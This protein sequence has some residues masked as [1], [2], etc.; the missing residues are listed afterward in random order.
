MRIKLVTLLVFFFIVCIHRILTT[1][2][3]HRH[4]LT[5]PQ[6]DNKNVN[7]EWS[8]CFEL[9]RPPLPTSTDPYPL[10]LAPYPLP[11]C[12]ALRTGTEDVEKEKHND[13]DVINGLEAIHQGLHDNL[14]KSGHTN[15][16]NLIIR[17]SP[18]LRRLHSDGTG[19]CSSERG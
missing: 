1:K 4:T 9:H 6:K 18:P 13:P 19:C 10:P 15:Q 3:K 5:T 14:A 17:S 2:Q 16:H 7:R 12:S 11:V 8:G